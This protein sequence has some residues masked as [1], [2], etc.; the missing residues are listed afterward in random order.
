MGRV[1]EKIFELVLS[2]TWTS[3]PM[4]VSKFISC[5]LQKSRVVVCGSLS[6]ASKAAATW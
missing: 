1:G 2:S 6:V 3:S 5:H 4:T